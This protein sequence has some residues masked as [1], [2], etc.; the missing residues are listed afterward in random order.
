MIF[1]GD[2]RDRIAD[3]SVSREADRLADHDIESDG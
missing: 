2:L 1:V 3:S